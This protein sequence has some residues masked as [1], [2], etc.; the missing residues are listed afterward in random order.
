MNKVLIMLLESPICN[1]GWKIKDFNLLGT[2]NK[3]YSLK[4]IKG[5]NG[6]IIAF[7]CNHCPYVKSIV[8]RMVSDFNILKKNGI[9]IVAIMPNNPIDYPEDNI[10]NM[11]IFSKKN[12]F[13]F[14]YLIDKNQATAKRYSAVCTPDF[15]C[16]NRKDELQY[17]GR[18][19]NFKFTKIKKIEK[20]LLNAVSLI[21]KKGTGPKIQNASVGCSIKWN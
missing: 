8:K 13:N 19:D 12:S 16:F 3:Y 21:I 14:P 1:F 7:I 6:T 9:G 2:D 20:E 15:F 11:T 18:L 10:E 5:K 4:E 17:R